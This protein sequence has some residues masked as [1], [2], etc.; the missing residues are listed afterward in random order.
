MFSDD[1]G[2]ERAGVEADT[3]LEF[4]SKT[5]VEPFEET[6]HLECGVGNAAGMILNRNRNASG[7][8]VA[9]ADCLDFLDAM[10]RGDEVE[11]TEKP[12]EHGHNGNGLGIPRIG[13]E[14]D[15]I[16]EA[17]GGGLDFFG[18]DIFTVLQ[19]GSDRFGEHIE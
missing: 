11:I 14:S 2:N 9:I 18:D 10:A 13:R 16:G 6:H 3:D 15:E 7:E 12:V 4:G 19:T 1:S 8:H 5:G 17:H